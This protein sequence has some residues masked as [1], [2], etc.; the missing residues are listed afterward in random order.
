MKQGYLLFQ[1]IFNLKCSNH[2][3]RISVKLVS[4]VG[5]GVIAAGVAKVRHEI[6][7]LTSF[8]CSFVFLRTITGTI[9]FNIVHVSDIS[10]SCN[11]NDS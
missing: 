2:M 5:V 7:V 3:S 4:E 10:N 8:G 9:G 6:M 11:I 1:L